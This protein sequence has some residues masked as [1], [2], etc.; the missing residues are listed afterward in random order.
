MCQIHLLDISVIP[1]A[2]YQSVYVNELSFPE[3][4]I[5]QN[6]TTLANCMF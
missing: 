1:I 2:L 3:I 5:S 6:N 4:V